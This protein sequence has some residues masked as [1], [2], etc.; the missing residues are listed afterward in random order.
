MPATK[1]DSP[2]LAGVERIQEPLRAAKKGTSIA[3]AQLAIAWCLSN[4]N[5]ST[6]ILGASDPEQ[7]GE[8]LQA[9]EKIALL[10][11][12]VTERIEDLLQ[13]KPDLPTQF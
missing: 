13:N 10:D 11:E 4:P 3:P 1:S 9:A 7:L 5:V 6:V 8:N 2:S 12:Q